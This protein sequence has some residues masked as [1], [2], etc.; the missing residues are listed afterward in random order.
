MSEADGDTNS[1]VNQVCREK[2]VK[3]IATDCYGGFCRL[4]ND[5]G[6]KF[7]VLDKNG[8]EIKECDII[9]ISEAEEGVVEILENQKHN[10]EDGDEVTLTKIEGMDLKEGKTHEEEA[11]KK[12]TS[13]NETIHK[14]KVLTPNSFKIGDTTKYKPY[15]GKGI[16]KALKTKVEL[17]GISFKET[18]DKKADEIPLDMNLMIVDFEK[19]AHNQIMH[20]CF[21][22]LD[23]FKK[24]KG[25]MPKAWS[26]VDARIFYD[27]AMK[28]AEAKKVDKDDLK[29]DSLMVK[30]FHMFPMMS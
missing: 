8:E 28:I 13:I 3:F 7:E 27:M 14:V 25:S 29:D 21:L 24:E 18:M 1:I 9:K 26:L 10:L 16:A 23:L 6:Q 5:F 4:F 15:T 17:K 11:F 20:I 22:A 19:L 12:L 2:G 30:F